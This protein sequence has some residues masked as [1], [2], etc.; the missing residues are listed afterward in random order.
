[1]DENLVTPGGAIM[2]VTERF[3]DCAQVFEPDV[4]RPG[5]KFLIQL[6]RSHANIHY[7]FGIEIKSRDDA[8]N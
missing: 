1:M 4:P 3:C 5:E 2:S 8:G 6:A 7:R